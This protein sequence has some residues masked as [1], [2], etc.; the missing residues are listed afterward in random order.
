MSLRSYCHTWP[1]RRY[2]SLCCPAWQLVCKHCIHWC[3]DLFGCKAARQLNWRSSQFTEDIW[4]SYSSHNGLL[5]SNSMERHRPE[6]VEFNAV[7]RVSGRSCA[8]LLAS[9]RSRRRQQRCPVE[10]QDLW[11]FTRREINLR[12]CQ[13]RHSYT[14]QASRSTWGDSSL[15]IAYINITVYDTFYHLLRKAPLRR[16]RDMVAQR[17]TFQQ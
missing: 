9:R 5:G 1:A 7:L 10:L 12:L 15:C 4:H 8:K 2:Y 13:R 3:I 11:A 17:S 16:F 14:G 6:T